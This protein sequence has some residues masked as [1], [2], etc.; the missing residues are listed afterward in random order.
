MSSNIA[1]RQLRSHDRHFDLPA[2]CVMSETQLT[3]CLEPIRQAASNLPLCFG[4]IGLLRRHGPM[5]AQSV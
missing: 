4:I 1:P 5:Y 3:D 2:C